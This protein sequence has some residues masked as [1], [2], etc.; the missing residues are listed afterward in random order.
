MPYADF[1][2]TWYRNMW[3]Y[4]R[5]WFSP[6]RA[7]ALRWAIIVGMMLRALAA[8]AG[9]RNGTSTRAEGLAAYRMVLKKALNRWD[10]SSPSSL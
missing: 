6:G 10:G 7:E 3:R 9:V 8:M 1:I 2:D 4:A 5:K